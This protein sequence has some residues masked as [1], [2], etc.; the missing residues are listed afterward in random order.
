MWERNVK[1]T[2]RRGDETQRGRSGEGTK[3]R[4]DGTERG[5]NGEGT[6]RQGDETTIKPINYVATIEIFTYL[7][8]RQIF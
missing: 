1:G 3:R 2:K 5:R 7:S 8:Q 4:G 6:K